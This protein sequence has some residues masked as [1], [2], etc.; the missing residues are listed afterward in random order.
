MPPTL[1]AVVASG[2]TIS[3]NVDLRRHVLEAIAVPVISSGALGVQAGFDTTSAL[4]TRILEPHGAVASG[5]LL[6]ATGVGSRVISYPR[7]VF[8]PPYMRLETVMATGSAQTDNRTFTML[9][10]PR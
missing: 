2:S 1:Y 7:D 8:T 9:T 5:D 10:R 4:F 6:F 3:G